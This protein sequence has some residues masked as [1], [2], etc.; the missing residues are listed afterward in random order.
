M[1]KELLRLGVYLQENNLSHNNI[2]TNNILVHD[3]KL[4]LTDF[5]EEQK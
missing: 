1:A 3:G 5:Y 2:S 4:K